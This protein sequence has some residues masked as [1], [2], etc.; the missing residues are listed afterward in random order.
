[1]R[2]EKILSEVFLQ[3]VCRA[4]NDTSLVFIKIKTGTLQIIILFSDHKS[5]YIWVMVNTK[6][7]LSGFYKHL[8]CKDSIGIFIITYDFED[9]PIPSWCI[10]YAI[11]MYQIIE[12]LEFPE[13]LIVSK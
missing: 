5:I 3:G 11:G 8:F 7:V 4:L 9:I 13:I 6:S 1:M 12:M 10:Y 2:N